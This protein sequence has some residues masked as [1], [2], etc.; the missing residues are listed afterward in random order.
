[1]NDQKPGDKAMM[2]QAALA[3]FID[4]IVTERNDPSIKQESLPQVK[5]VLLKELNDAINTQLINCL[6]EDDQVALD[7]LLDKNSSDDELNQFFIEKIPNLEVEIASALLTFRNAYLSPVSQQQ[8]EDMS[9]TQNPSSES[10]Q[11]LTDT[12]EMPPPPPPPPAPVMPETSSSD[13]PP[14]PAPAP[15]ESN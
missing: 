15:N 14:S 11:M 13:L 10:S 7:E 2:D 5:V 4:K 6:S 12:S 3:S 8:G 9:M 1:M